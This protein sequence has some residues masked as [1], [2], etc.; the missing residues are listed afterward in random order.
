METCDVATKLEARG[1]NWAAEKLKTRS[2]RLR[3]LGMRG[4][5]VQDLGRVEV[6]M[7]S[8]LLLEGF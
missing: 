4:V 5:R 7:S 3:D 6:L 1:C 8:G 2:F